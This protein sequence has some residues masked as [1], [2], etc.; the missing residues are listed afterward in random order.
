VLAAVSY[1]P[2]L[3]THVGKVGAD[4]KQYL[5]LDPGRLLA[6]APSMWDPNVGM[7]TVTHQNIGYL[8]PMGPWY[9]VFHA[10]A[11]PTWVAQ[12]LWTGTLLFTAGLGVVFLIGSLRPEPQTGEGAASR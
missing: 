7:G 11:V 10:L 3:F 4:T 2:L 9:W 1:V 5:Y 12:R 6:R 8:L